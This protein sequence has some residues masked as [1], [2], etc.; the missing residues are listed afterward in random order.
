MAKK[1]YAIRQKEQIARLQEVVFDY[2]EAVF[3]AQ[4]AV[5]NRNGLKNTPVYAGRPRTVG[6]E[7]R[8]PVRDYE[9]VCEIIEAL[10]VKL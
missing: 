8:M 1:H 5:Q 7:E 10:P 4:R 3:D 6:N 9:K 2:Y